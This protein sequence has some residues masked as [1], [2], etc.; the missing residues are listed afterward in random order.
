[1]WYLFQ[2]AIIFAVVA[3]DLHWGWAEHNN[4]ISGGAGAL[5]AWV[6]TAALSWLRLE[7]K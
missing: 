4:L 5:L 6:V 7:E 2:C 3:T 1:M